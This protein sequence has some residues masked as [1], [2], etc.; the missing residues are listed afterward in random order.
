[1]AIDPRLFHALFGVVRSG[2]AVFGAAVAPQMRPQP[3]PSFGASFRPTQTVRPVAA[4]PVA[5]PARVNLGSV[6]RPCGCGR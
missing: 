4:Q 5:A 2:A 1:M 3:W 6:A